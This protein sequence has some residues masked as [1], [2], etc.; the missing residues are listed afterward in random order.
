MTG[1]AIVGLGFA[2]RDSAQSPENALSDMVG[3]WPA[4]QFF[5]DAEATAPICEQIFAS[6]I[7][8]RPIRL[9]LIGTE[10]DVRVWEALL[11]IPMGRVVNYIDIARQ[12]GFPTAMRA[13]GAAVG[14]NPISF[15]VPCHRVLRADGGLGGY[16]W[17]LAR[18]RAMLAWE[19]ARSSAP[20][21]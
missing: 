13:V 20:R 14:R 18:K 3:R 10:F 5:E 15:L 8:E 7:P 6:D 11:G 12:I 16:H 2:D 1:E 9:R 19:K 21:S 17:G 4:A